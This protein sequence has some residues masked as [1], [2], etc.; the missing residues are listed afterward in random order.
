MTDA[1]VIEQ[2]YAILD[3]GRIEDAV[4]LLDESIEFAIV[5]PGTVRRGYSRADM[6]SYLRGRPPVDRRHV[7]LRTSSA[8]DVQFAYGSV[9]ENETKTTGY[10][11]A[12]MH[13]DDGTIDAYE[14]SFDTEF[15]ILTKELAHGKRD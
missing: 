10:F 1:L 6:L 9:I 12:A 15:S 14:V 13:V 11:L 5:L 4:A 7:L 2:Y 3:S 8:G